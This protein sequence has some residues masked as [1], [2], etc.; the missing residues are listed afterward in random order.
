MKFLYS[1]QQ[2]NITQKQINTLSKRLDSYTEQLRNT[3]KTD[4]YETPESVL[5]CCTDTNVINQIQRLKKELVSSKLRYLF[6]VGIGGSNLGTKAVYDAFLGAY[7]FAQ[8]IQPQIIFLDTNN[9]AIHQ[10][11]KKI[12]QAIKSEEEI[13]IN[14]ISKSGGTT[15]TIANAEFLIDE[16]RK[17]FGTCFNRIVITSEENSA[18]WD[19]S[20]K[21]GFYLLKHENVGGRFSVLSSVGLFPLVCLGFNIKK[22]LEGARIM[23]D[24]CLENK[25][26]NALISA[27]ILYTQYKKSKNIHDT[28]IFDT[29]LE[30]L[31]KWYRQLMGESLGK[32][33]SITGKHIRTGIT[34]TVSIGSIDLHSVGQLYLGGPRDKVTTFVS[35]KKR[36]VIKIPKRRAFPTVVPG[37][38]GKTMDDIMGA[39]LDGTKIAYTKQK[40]PFMEIIFDNMSV[41]E[42]GAFFQ[43]KMLEMMY[44]GKLLAV[45]TFNQPHVELYKK[46][47]KK[48]LHG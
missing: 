34:P 1:S 45:D 23:R 19:A 26:N 17:K 16:V 29:Q 31:G 43:F 10:R 28:F 37:I 46:E 44:L 2:S 5:N 48:I 27:S 38:K 42:L 3:I 24:Q 9:P 6:L 40:L 30:S 21:Q 25:E 12:I 47:T 41:D 35:L 33:F 7:E 18:L 8:Q 4:G 32:E 11:I 13:L 36:S 22:F 14:V 15:E 39:I 20:L